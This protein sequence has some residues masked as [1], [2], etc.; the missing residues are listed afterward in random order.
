MI[1]SKGALKSISPVVIWMLL[2]FIVPLFLVVVVSFMTRGQYG[3]IQYKIT[4]GNYAKLL[5]PLYIRILWNS[6]LISAATML[7]C[8]IFGY[9]FAYFVARSPKIYRPILLML[10]ILPFWTN[11]LIR[12]Y[13]W[14]ILLRTE[15][16]INTYLLKLGI[17]KAPLTLLYN[18]T[19]V[20]IGMVYMMFPFMVLPL[21]SSIEKLDKSLLEAASDL[22]ATPVRAFLKVT[23]PLTKP[24]IF[25]GCLLVFVPTLGYF[26]I[27]DLMGGSKIILISNLIKNQF[28]SARNWPFGSAISVIL[29]VIMFVTL[30]IY[31]KSGGSK[32]KMEVL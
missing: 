2:F 30:L 8:L 10:I 6:I 18:N 24:G 3:D 12:T 16:I 27:P 1:K 32:D 5:N 26:F 31:I 28:L 13:A 21:Y 4:S 15:G 9:P 29:I 20:L 11:S 23:L 19:A 22:G 25:S 17:I 7:L 14:I